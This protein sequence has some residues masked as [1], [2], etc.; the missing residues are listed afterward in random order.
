M[1]PESTTVHTPAV[2]RTHPPEV[3]A[4]MPTAFIVIFLLFFAVLAFA[5]FYVQRA[6]TRDTDSTPAETATTTE[7]TDPAS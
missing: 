1:S 3:Q 2:Y 4:A 6:K 5:W 7:H